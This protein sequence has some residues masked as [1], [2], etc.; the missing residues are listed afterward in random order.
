MARSVPS[1]IHLMHAQAL[2]DLCTQQLRMSP[3]MIM[4][5]AKFTRVFHDP[6]I[7]CAIHNAMRRNNLQALY[8]LSC[9]TYQR[10]ARP[11]LWNRKRVDGMTSAIPPE[12]ECFIG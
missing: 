10:H 12:S 3:G 2:A 1:L 4:H 5:V 6:V 11:A 9:E 8:G 7:I